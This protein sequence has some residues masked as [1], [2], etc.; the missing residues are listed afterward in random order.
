MRKPALI[1]FAVTIAVLVP[2]GM[3]ALDAGPAQRAKLFANKSRSLDVDDAHIEVAL[4]HNFVNAGGTVHVKLTADKPTKVAVVVVGST[5]SEATRVENPPRAVAHEVVELTADANGQI[6][7]DVPVRLAGAAIEGGASALAHYQFFVMAPDVADKFE[8]WR[9][10]RTDRQR[11]RAVAPASS[12]LAKLT[13]NIEA[14]WTPGYQSVRYRPKSIASLDAYTRQTYAG[15]SLKAPDRATADEAFV[16]IVEVKNP[17]KQAVS[18][19][20]AMHLP[21]IDDRSIDR[22]S[23]TIEGPDGAIELAA[24]ETRRV[25]FKVTARHKGVLALSATLECDCKLP[26]KA[27]VFEAIDIVAPHPSVAR[28]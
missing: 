18:V 5:G 9:R 13:T 10:A 8:D 16:A 19:N 24:G 2:A 1:A 12:E 28:R 14:N 7:A 6:A 26:Y 3:F 20:L 23:V 15:F 17:A 22:D 25:E 27:P 4:D 21:S 11:N